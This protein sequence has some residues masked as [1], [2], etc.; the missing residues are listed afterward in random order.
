MSQWY[1]NY[2]PH[3]V[4]LVLILLFSL[5]NKY[6]R[7]LA[8]KFAAHS[9]IRPDQVKSVRLWMKGADGREE[10]EA[11]RSE[12]ERLIAWFNDAVFIQRR[13]RMQDRSA[14]SGAVIELET[15]E[16]IEIFLEGRDFDVRRQKPGK[17]E[18]VYWAKKDELKEFLTRL[19]TQS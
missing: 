7:L 16:T 13:E 10:W 18:V 15:G 14:P 9:K 8:E 12:M 19:Q 11:S 4:G 6:W 1:T 3:L 2:I 5:P 17:K